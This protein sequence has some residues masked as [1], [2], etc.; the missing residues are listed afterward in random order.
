M[1][2]RNHILLFLLGLLLVLLVFPIQHKL[3]FACVS[4]VF[5][6]FLT[7]D[8]DKQLPWLKH[9]SMITH[10]VILT[11]LCYLMYR[12]YLSMELLG[13]FGFAAILPTFLHLLGDLGGVQGFGL[14]RLFDWVW[15]KRWSY[16]WLLFNLLVMISYVVIL[17]V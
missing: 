2:Q 5:A 17:Y 12:P 7:P 14:I 9:R 1:N 13:E 8:I 4:L 11:I 16:T 3:E 15:S 6:V 10:S